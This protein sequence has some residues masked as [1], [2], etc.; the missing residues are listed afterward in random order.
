MKERFTP[1][2]LR[3]HPEAVFVFG[4][5]LA[6]VGKGG[7]AVVRDEPNAFGIP[8]KRDPAN[9]FGDREDERAAVLSA[10]EALKAIAEDHTLVFPEGG[11]GTGLA[12]M[13]EFSPLLK[14]ETD[15][16]LRIHFLYD[17][18]RPANL[19]LEVGGYLAFF[20]T[21]AALELAAATWS[22]ERDTRVFVQNDGEMA[23]YL[24]RYVRKPQSAAGH[25]VYTHS[26]GTPASE[27]KAG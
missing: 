24:V 22:R 11:F 2:L 15:D 12:R 26:P 23:I 17:N 3:A 1:E 18:G 20:N 25:F 6:G 27:L 19:G 7:Q 4:D 5:N 10:I 9:F 14:R 16:L 8:T 13:A 21:F